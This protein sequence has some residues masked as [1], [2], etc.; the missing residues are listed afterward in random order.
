M[1]V[2]L[3][4]TC[5]ANPSGNSVVSGGTGETAQQAWL[6]Q[7]FLASGKAVQM[8]FHG[9]DNWDVLSP[10]CHELLAS[11]QLVITAPLSAVTEDAVVSLLHINICP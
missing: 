6:Y 5:P 10:I 2:P 8:H 9:D 3:Q 1:N 11:T 7:A 4:G